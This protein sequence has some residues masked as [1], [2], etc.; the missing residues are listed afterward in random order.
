MD[1]STTARPTDEERPHSTETPL[2]VFG[3]RLPLPF[4]RI[5]KTESSLVNMRRGKFLEALLL[6]KMGRLPIER[7]PNAPRYSFA[8]E[9]FAESGRYGWIQRGEFRELYR[10][11]ALLLGNLSVQVWIVRYLLDWIGRPHGFVRNADG[12]LG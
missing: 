4:L 1:I 8:G 2:R 6:R 9:E 7:P 3:T 10:R 12:T 5:L 11:D